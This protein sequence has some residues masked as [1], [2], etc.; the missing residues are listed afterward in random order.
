MCQI[1]AFWFNKDAV[2][3]DQLFRQSGL[4][5]L[6]WDEVHYGDGTTYGEKTI[7]TAIERTAEV[8][9]SSKHETENRRGRNLTEQFRMWLRECYGAFTI[10]QIYKELNV[11]H[12]KD[13]NLIRV[14]LSREVEKGHVMGSYRMVDREAD[15]LEILE[16]NPSP[17]LIRFP[18]EIENYVHIYEGNIIV[19]AGSPNAGKTAFDLN[20]A[21]ENRHRY[22]IIYWSSEM[23]SEELRIRVGKFDHPIEEWKKIE[24]RKRTHDFHQIVSP[25]AVNVIDYLEVTEGEFFRI[26]DNIRKIFEKLDKGIALIS[27]QMD[28]GAKFAWGGQKTLDK[29]RLYVT[30]D[31]NRMVI[32]KG[33]NRA[34]PDVNPNGLSRSFQLLQGSN[35]L[36][37]KWERAWWRTSKKFH[38]EHKRKSFFFLCYFLSFYR[39]VRCL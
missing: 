8:F 38:C 4:I 36:W 17:L 20:F 25:D 1:L 37:D 32:V 29:A 26:G 35:F 10:E 12:L 21:Y 6:K 7:K 15:R 14:N 13:K 18:G 5:R 28:T 22:E 9:Q 24:F 16:R 2:K 33:K 39:G 3:I 19:N 23:G 27:L 31:K 30:L 11:T 34:C